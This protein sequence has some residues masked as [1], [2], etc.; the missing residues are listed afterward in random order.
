MNKNF[1]TICIPQDSLETIMNFIRPN[2]SNRY[3]TKD[4]ADSYLD[5]NQSDLIKLS[6]ASFFILDRNTAYLVYPNENRNELKR[7]IISI[8]NPNGKD[9]LC[10][11]F[12]IKLVVKSSIYI[13]NGIPNPQDFLDVSTSGC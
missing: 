10:N 3:L 13:N 12:N 9:M 11:D 8:K 4:E 2:I 7:E 1:T 6:Q 5:S